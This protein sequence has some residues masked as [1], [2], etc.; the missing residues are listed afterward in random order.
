MKIN[1]YYLTTRFF[2]IYYSRLRF[3]LLSF[4]DIRGITY[5]LSFAVDDNSTLAQCRSHLP[6]LMAYA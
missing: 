6:R 4:A 2:V 3:K 1:L 5:V